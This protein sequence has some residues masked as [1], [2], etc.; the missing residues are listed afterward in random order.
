MF[1][2]L[3]PKVHSHVLAGVARRHEHLEQ[4][5]M[6]AFL[7]LLHNGAAR[8]LHQSWARWVLATREGQGDKLAHRTRRTTRRKQT[9]TSRRMPGRSCAPG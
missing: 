7:H 1:T 2:S 3:P 6:V 4:R 8:R 5:A 9:R